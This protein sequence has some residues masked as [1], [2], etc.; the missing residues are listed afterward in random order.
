M[1]R[2]YTLQDIGHLSDIYRTFIGHIGHMT[3]EGFSVSQKV[4]ALRD[5]MT[6]QV[7]RSPARE[8]RY[9]C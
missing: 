8:H 5:L 1:C 3:S 2:E 6:L 9:L 7:C 4:E